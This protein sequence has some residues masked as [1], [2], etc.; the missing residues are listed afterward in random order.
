MKKFFLIA[1][2]AMIAGLVNAQPPKGP[3]NKGDIYG[4]K[5]KEDGAITVDKLTAA[6]GEN[7]KMNTKLIGKVTEVCSKK[8]CWMKLVSG[9]NEEVF[10]KFK[11]YGF[12]VPMEL[13]G[14][15]I[16]LEGEAKMKMVSVD[17]QKHYLED[18]KKPQS[19]IDAITAPKKEIRFV[20][21]GVKVI[22]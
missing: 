7:E 11:D 2:F 18:A 15:T 6:M 1:A 4:E 20:A 3:V 9:N 8:G 19:E 21:S 5:I 16:A 17:E 10:V 13:V 14:H 22:D 12:F